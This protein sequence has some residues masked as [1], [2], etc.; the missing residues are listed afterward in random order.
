MSWDHRLA[1]S[2][3]EAVL[4]IVAFD[5]IGILQDILFQISSLNTNIKEVRTGL[6]KTLGEMRALVTVELRDIE[7]FSKLKHGIESVSDILSVE[8]ALS[9]SEEQPQ[10]QAPK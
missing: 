3:Y 8:R 1:N 7:H 10:D 4:S 6:S 9:S 5:R 2:T